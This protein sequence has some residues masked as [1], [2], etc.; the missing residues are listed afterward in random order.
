MPIYDQSYAHWKGRL[1]GHIFR[2]LPITLNGIRLAFRSKFFIVLFI[3]GE[4]PFIIFAGWIVL[5]HVIGVESIQRIADMG[6]FHVLFLKWQRFGVI[7]MCLFVGAPLISRDLKAG[8]LEVYFSKPLLL[9]D[10]LFGKFAIIAFFLACMT[11][12]PALLIFLFDLLLSDKAGYIGEVSPYL[13]GILLSSLWIIFLCSSIVLA[14]SSLARTARTAGIIWF[15]FHVGLWVAAR[16]SALIFNNEKFEIVN[17][18]RS[19]HA[20]SEKLIQGTMPYD[21]MH[22]SIPSVYLL[23]LAVGSLS[24]LLIRIKGVEVVES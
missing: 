16:I 7:A 5:Y 18:A 4:V 15:A 23:F 10:Y 3:L 17:I 2:W 19:L 8:A 22:V 1:E 6:E 21:D 13:P 24:L 14:A 12:F 11:L 9:F 20:V